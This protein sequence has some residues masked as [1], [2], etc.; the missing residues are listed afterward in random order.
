L[1]TSAVSYYENIAKGAIFLFAKYYFK[2]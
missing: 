2:F 1:Q